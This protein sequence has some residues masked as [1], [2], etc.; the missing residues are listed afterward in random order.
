MAL[1]KTTITL[2]E[3]ELAIFAVLAYSPAA[4]ALYAHTLVA[5]KVGLSPAQVEDAK[6]GKTPKDLSEREEATYVMAGELV[7]M[8]GPLSEEAFE[9]ARKVLGR[10]GVAAIV[11]TTGSFLYS[12]FLLNVADVPAPGDEKI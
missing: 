12:S 3:R 8:R 5:D 7:R 2:R 10:E 6:N 4:Y 11:H 9:R 1:T